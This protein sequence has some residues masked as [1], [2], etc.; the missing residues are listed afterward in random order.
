MLEKPVRTRTT[1]IATSIH[2][3]IQ[4]VTDGHTDTRYIQDTAAKNCTTRKLGHCATENRGYI[5]GSETWNERWRKKIDGTH[6][7][8]T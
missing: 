6:Q 8:G 3:G 7:Q 4:P 2:H 5:K 1:K